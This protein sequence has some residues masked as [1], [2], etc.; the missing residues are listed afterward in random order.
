MMYEIN[1]DVVF[2]KGSLNGAIYDFNTNKV[3]S[4]NTDA[5]EIIQKLVRPDALLTD[6]EKNYVKQLEANNL[7]KEDYLVTEYFPDSSES[8]DLSMVWLEITQACNL[9]CLHCYEGNAHVASRNLLSLDKWKSIIVELKVL[10]VNRVVVIGG[11]PCAHKDIKELLIFLSNKKIDITLF[12]NGT[13]LDDELMNIIIKNQ[14]KVKVSLYG[15]IAEIHDAITIRKGSFEK[16][17]KSIHLLK[18]NGVTVDVAVVAMKENQE[19]LG[20]IQAF[21]KSLDITYRG[22]DVIRNVFGG[23]QSEHTPNKKEVIAKAKYTKPVFITYKNQ[24]DA[25]FRRNSCW[26]GKFAITENGDIIPCVFERNVVYGNVNTNSLAEI[27]VSETLKDNWFRDFSKIETCRDCEFRF[28][29]KDCRPLGI[30]VC[31]N[32]NEK[33]PRCLYNPYSGEWHK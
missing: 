26:Y 29:C 20:E 21:I 31:G 1:Q 12:T 18:S 17:V 5:C 4:V 7:Y 14:I 10:A 16:L 6:N 13:L 27:L 23:S 30:S 2:V 33:N 32:L 3:F 8:I 15:H 28:A 24:F 9:R 11:E 25:N 22:Y 19:H